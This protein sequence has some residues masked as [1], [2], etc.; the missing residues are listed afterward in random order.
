MGR[1]RGI[2]RGG[3]YP[4]DRGASQHAFVPRT[5]HPSAKTPSKKPTPL[6][7]TSPPPPAKIRV[8]TLTQNP[9]PKDP[10]SVTLSPTFCHSIL[11]VVRAPAA[12][13]FADAK[14][15]LGVKS[16]STTC[17][18]LVLRHAQTRNTDLSVVGEA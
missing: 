14:A 7:Q 5:P 16:S 18:A 2:F 13:E 6:R 9:R 4:D 17:P 11:P 1:R 10:D 12:K 3:W 8:P 15:T